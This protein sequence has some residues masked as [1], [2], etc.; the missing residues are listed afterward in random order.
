MRTFIIALF[1]LSMVYLFTIPKQF[2]LREGSAVSISNP[3]ATFS[4]VYDYSNSEIY[5]N[6]TNQYM[7]V[8]DYIRCTDKESS[9]Y[10]Q[11]LQSAQ[12]AFEDSFNSYSR[13]GSIVASE[14]SAAYQMSFKLDKFCYGNP[15]GGVTTNSKGWA[16]GSVS[17]IDTTTGSTV[18]VFDFN[19][20]S[21]FPVGDGSYDLAAHRERGYQLVASYLARYLNNLR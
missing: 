2:D 8:S 15:G 3:S 14:S 10:Y 16:T 6:A 21:A 12:K 4:V 13:K 20:I 1:A 19:K 11:E 18:A 7:S 5:D 9:S 17:V